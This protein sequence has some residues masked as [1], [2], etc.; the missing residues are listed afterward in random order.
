M[1]LTWVKL[2]NLKGPKGNVGTWYK[3]TLTESDNLDTIE[4]GAY[5]IQSG[6][7]A[8]ALGLPP[9]QGTLESLPMGDGATQRFTTSDGGTPELRL[10]TWERASHGTSWPSPAFQRTFPTVVDTRMTAFTL[11]HPRGMDSETGRNRQ[12]RLPFKLG[13]KARLRRVCFRNYDYNSD[14]A[15]VGQIDLRGG[16]LGE[17]QMNPDGSMTG[18][19][20]EGS[21]VTRI[22][23][24][25]LSPADSGVFYGD[26]VNI[27]LE[28]HK[29][30]LLSYAFGATEDQ[31]V[32]R[33][34]GRCFSNTQLGSWNTTG[35][36]TA[37]PQ[38]Y[39]GLHVWMEL[40][41]E[42]DVPVWLYVG[43]SQ[44]AGLATTN[45]A[46]DSWARKHAYTHGA[47]PQILAQPGGS[48][49]DYQDTQR[50]MLRMWDHLDKPDRVYIAGLG[51]NDISNGTPF[52]GM[53]YRFATAALNIMEHFGKNLYLTTTLPRTE[54][55]PSDAV[56]RAYNDW[57]LT[58]L[59]GNAIMGADHF[60]EVV[61]ATSGLMAER[62]RGP[63]NDVHMTSAGNA[64]VA[65]ITP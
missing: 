14:T 44:L 57:L 21:T 13:A 5:Q 30:Y 47:I 58:M 6:I 48:L 20:P 61:D 19:F 23:S 10:E 4:F 64:R 3:R 39:G 15:G 31:T 1:A 37:T 2:G 42:G 11:N 16:G 54:I 12:Y 22:A 25:Q 33:Q 43:D 60:A 49:A 8:T 18:L 28:P 65:A 46:Y 34:L 29:E 32:I 40:E 35:T 36:V 63:G 59:P 55:H 7:V 9:R 56:R 41:V 53:Q 24:Q 26:N 51:S 38:T 17:H 45:P 27:E 62:W 52:T 50:R